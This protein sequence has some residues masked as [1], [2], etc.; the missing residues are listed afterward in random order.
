MDMLFKILVL[1]VVA[2]GG[3]ILVPFM[4]NIMIKIDLL[5]STKTP[6]G[7]LEDIMRLSTYIW[8]GSTA[9]AVISLFIKQS[10]RTALLL[11]PLILPSLFLVIYTIIQ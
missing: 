7:F 2:A 3:F 1:I 9:P 5:D 6:E 11:C 4:V 8:M 10:W